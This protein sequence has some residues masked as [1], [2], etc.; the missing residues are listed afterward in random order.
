MLWATTHHTAAELIVERADSGQPNMGLKS[1]EGSRVRKQDVTI[2]KNYLDHPE[3]EELNRIVVM[4]LDHA[5][6]QA[7]RRRPMTMSEWEQR[8]DTFLSF[9]ERD[10]LDHAG[11][12]SAQVAE[13][14]ALERYEEFDV[15]RREE[16]KVIA[17]AED[18]LLL[19]EL[20]AKTQTLPLEK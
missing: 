2:V 4:Y 18:I 8:L 13:K 9:N 20:R 1:F 7:K 19:E 10:L 6:D 12:I 3:I 15:K 16:A 5:E 11:K 14:L 17:D